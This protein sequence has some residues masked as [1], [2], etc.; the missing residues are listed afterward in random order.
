MPFKQRYAVINMI[1]CLK[2][3]LIC[4]TIKSWSSLTS[5]RLFKALALARENKVPFTLI[6]IETFD[7][8]AAFLS[9]SEAFHCKSC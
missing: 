6:R 1:K 8:H 4:N 3:I 2:L 5:K 9:F 7:F